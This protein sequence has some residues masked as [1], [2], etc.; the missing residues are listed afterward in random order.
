MQ[1]GNTIIFVFWKA[2]SVLDEDKSAGR[3]VS[4]ESFAEVVMAGTRKGAG[5]EGRRKEGKEGR[6]EGRKEGKE[7]G[8]GEGR[9]ERNGNGSL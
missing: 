6:K 5:W 8:R 7:K 9:K 1:G 4:V 2:L 3:E